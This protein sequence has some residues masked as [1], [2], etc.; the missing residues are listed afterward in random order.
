MESA[1]KK[2]VYEDPA[3]LL[4][5]WW[6]LSVLLASTFHLWDLSNKNQKRFHGNLCGHMN[7]NVSESQLKLET[8]AGRR[9]EFFSFC[10]SIKWVFWRVSIIHISILI[11]IKIILESWYCTRAR[12]D[13]LCSIRTIDPFQMWRQN[14]WTGGQ[15][16]RKSPRCN[17]VYY[18]VLSSSSTAFPPTESLFTAGDISVQHALFS[19]RFFECIIVHCFSCM[20]DSFY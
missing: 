2:A 8:A 9:R 16:K 19:F 5:L 11:M 7:W 15:D 6:A 13:R 3:T 20:R 10:V 4:L 17:E 1:G 18:H 14:L 12:Y